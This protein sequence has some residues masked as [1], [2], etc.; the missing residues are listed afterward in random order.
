MQSIVLF[1]SKR[2]ICLDCSCYLFHFFFVNLDYYEN[3]RKKYKTSFQDIWSEDDKYKLWLSQA[4]STNCGYPKQV[5]VIQRNAK[6]VQK[7]FLWQFKKS[8]H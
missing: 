6:C 8:K 4:I 5:T 7:F 3:V 2:V 1:G